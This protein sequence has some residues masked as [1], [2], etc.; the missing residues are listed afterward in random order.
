[1]YNRILLYSI[2]NVTVK[3]C[4]DEYRGVSNEKWKWTIC[5]NGK[6]NQ[7]KAIKPEDETDGAG[8]EGRYLQ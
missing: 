6:E 1:M 4:Y 8:G 5:R 2:V 3:I 7:S